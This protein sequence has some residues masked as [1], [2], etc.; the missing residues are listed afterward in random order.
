MPFANLQLDRSGSDN[1]EPENRADVVTIEDIHVSEEDIEQIHI[2]GHTVSVH[3]RCMHSHTFTLYMYTIEILERMYTCTCLPV[4]LL[5]CLQ[6]TSM[7]AKHPD[8]LCLNGK[9]VHMHIATCTAVVELCFKSFITSCS[10]S[11]IDNLCNHK[12]GSDFLQVD[13][14]KH[15]YLFSPLF[16]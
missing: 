5:V 2:G 16:S 13:K 8:Y 4:F 6:Y 15:A 12:I 9:Q 1:D 3:V 14:F 11:L 10:G 7:L